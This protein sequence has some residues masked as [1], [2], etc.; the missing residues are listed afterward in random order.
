MRL[1]VLLVGLDRHGGLFGEVSSEFSN[2]TLHS[3]KSSNLDPV[4][5]TVKVMV[6][7]GLGLIAVSV[8]AGIYG[9]YQGVGKNLIVFWTVFEINNDIPLS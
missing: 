3:K 1:Y 7:I 6:E 2:L 9:L 4:F 5:I 8:F